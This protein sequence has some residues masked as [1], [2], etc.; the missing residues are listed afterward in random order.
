[1]ENYWLL[2]HLLHNPWKLHFVLLNSWRFSQDSE[3]FSFISCTWVSCFYTR[4]K[5]VFSLICFHPPSLLNRNLSKGEGSIF[6]GGGFLPLPLPQR[7]KLFFSVSLMSI[8]QPKFLFWIIFFV[9]LVS[10]SLFSHN[11]IL[12]ICSKK[13]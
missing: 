10:C 13:V 1:M 6:H 2:M 4:F 5:I 9:R 3:H 7:K 11:W 8:W 12:Y